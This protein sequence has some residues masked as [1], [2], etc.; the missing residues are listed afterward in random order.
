MTMQLQ[1]SM[2]TTSDLSRAGHSLAFDK[3]GTGKVARDVIGI[4][5]LG[6]VGG[7]AVGALSQPQRIKLGLH[8]WKL[9]VRA[10]YSYFALGPILPAMRGDKKVGFR[11]GSRGVVPMAALFPGPLGMYMT[12]STRKLPV[13]TFGFGFVAVDKEEPFFKGPIQSRGGEHTTSSGTPD[14]TKSIVGPSAKPETPIG[15]TSTITP[16]G[17][18]RGYGGK[19]AGG[20]RKARGRR[21]PYCWVHKK[22]HFCKFV[23]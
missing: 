12:S 7:R 2:V 9:G 17:P 20:S 3:T 19:T 14:T 21:T 4:S 8:S 18:H 1:P 22:R 6:G 5:L 10:A 23:K 16:R 11:F 15:G 13:P